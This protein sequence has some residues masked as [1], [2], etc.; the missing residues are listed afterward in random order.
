[1]VAAVFRLPSNCVHACSW[2][3]PRPSCHHNTRDSS[4]DPAARRL[5]GVV[6]INNVVVVVQLVRFCIGSGVVGL[7]VEHLEVRSSLN[8]SKRT[9]C[10]RMATGMTSLKLMRREFFNVVITISTMDTF[11]VFLRT[12]STNSALNTHQT[13]LIKFAFF[14]CCDT[15]VYACVCTWNNG[16]PLFVIPE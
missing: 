8:A 16:S 15:R 1:M 13:K 3:R 14:F 9:A 2:H 7:V 5:D 11:V 10:R 4:I 6:R 12:R